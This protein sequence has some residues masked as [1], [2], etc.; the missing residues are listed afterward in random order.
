VESCVLK[1]SPKPS[2]VPLPLGTLMAWLVTPL[3]SSPV[4][5]AKG[6]TLPGEDGTCVAVMGA[7]SA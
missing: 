2:T 4:G 7:S 3:L 6:S 1:L 5:S